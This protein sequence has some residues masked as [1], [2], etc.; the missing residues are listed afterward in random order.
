MFPHK[1]PEDP[2]DAEFL[3]VAEI[4]KDPFFKIPSD[5][6]IGKHLYTHYELFNNVSDDDRTTYKELGGFKT[7]DGIEAFDFTC[8]NR[9]ELLY[10]VK[11]YSLEKNFQVYQSYQFDNSLKYEKR[12]D[13]IDEDLPDSSTTGA[14][15]FKCFYSIPNMTKQQTRK[16]FAG[17]KP[18]CPFY[19]KY[20]LNVLSGYYCLEDYDDLHNH[21]S[22]PDLRAYA[23]NKQFGKSLDEITVNN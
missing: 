21:P 16:N 22:T 4:I 10:R 3:R 23:E 20:S 5:S 1:D 8:C 11:Y 6:Q 13:T 18:A 14:V 2:I 15:K 12:T 7:Q 9:R 19:L 17:P